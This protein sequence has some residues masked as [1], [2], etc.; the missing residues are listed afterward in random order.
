V[1]LDETILRPLRERFGTPRPLRFAAEVAEDEWALVTRDRS[2]VHDVTLFVFNGDRL[3]L[4]RKQA[5]PPELWRPPGGGV[6]PGENFVEA[7]RREAYEETGAEIELDRYLVVTDATF[8]FRGEQ[9]RWSTHVF[10][11][12]TAT[13]ELHV[14]D[15]NE[16]AETRWG[17]VDELQGAVRGFQLQARRTFWRY[18]VALHDATVIA[19]SR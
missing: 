1:H 14:V 3:V 17:S 5:H 4:I 16:I 18:R 2:R 9:L 19:L 10:C 11:A 7:A 13:E 6:T 15:T 12:H 8:S